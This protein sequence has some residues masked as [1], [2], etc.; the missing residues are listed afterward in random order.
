MAK[1]ELKRECIRLRTEENLPYNEI[2]KRVAVSKGS[3]SLW[4]RNYPPLPREKLA[5]LRDNRKGVPYKERGA[6]SKFQRVVDGKELS[7]QQKMRI[8]E[9]ATL[10]RLALHGFNVLGPVFDGERMDWV[11]ENTETGKFSKLQVRWARAGT[12]GLP[13]I[14]LR[15]TDGSKGGK[16]N[17]RKYTNK[18][19][20]F[21][22][23]YDLYT[24]TAYVWSYRDLEDHLSAVSV[25][26]S[27]AERWDK[28]IAFTQ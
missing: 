3:L 8:A 24:D 17:K 25:T 12:V 27:A 21:I 15:C 4:L 6:V 5:S 26:D 7:S 19:F 10:F 9:A 28:I 16:Y 1:P 18:E 11:A 13:L 20:D 2:L 22:V 23:A 14:S